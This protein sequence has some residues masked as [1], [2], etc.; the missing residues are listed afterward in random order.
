MII[1]ETSKKFGFVMTGMG[2]HIAR[3]MMLRDLQ[4]LLAAS[5]PESSWAD[6]RTA[7]LTENILLKPTESARKVGLRRLKQLYGLDPEIMVFRALRRLWD[8]DPAAQPLLALLSA[9]AR[10]PLLRATVETVIHLPVDT[11]VTAPF[12]EQII[13]EGYGGH[14]NAKTLASV[15]RNLASS[16]TQ[17]GHF[18][19]STEKKRQ[20]V[21]SGPIVTAYAL[22]LAYLCDGRGDALF[23][24][25]WVGLLDTPKHVL[26]EQ[27]QQAS[28]LGWLEYRH[29]GA[30]TEISF[31]QLLGKQA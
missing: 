24:T 13:R 19:G 12:F 20:A 8:Q 1:A 4:A 18:S 28:Q 16:W 21:Q 5:S 7:V 10:E 2:A 22:F 9:V 11:T 30:I 29:S 31:R 25:P 23:D 26:Y 14:L 27:A 3:T 6:Y 17:S 15:G